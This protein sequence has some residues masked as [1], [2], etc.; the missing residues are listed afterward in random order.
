MTTLPNTDKTEDT[1][2]RGVF[3]TN[4]EV[5]GKVVNTL[6]SVWYILSTGS[7]LKIV[8]V[9]KIQLQKKAQSYSQ[10]KAN[11]YTLGVKTPS[12]STVFFENF[13][14]VKI[15]SKI[16]LIQFTFAMIL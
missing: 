16:S 7:Y 12:R 3:L 5:F 2:L 6:L 8:G 9:S 15:S 4:F 11:K 1:A 14:K 13:M 10:D